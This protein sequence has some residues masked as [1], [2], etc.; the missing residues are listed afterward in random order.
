MRWKQT[1]DYHWR[2][3]CGRYFICRSLCYV[4]SPLG[5]WVFLAWFRCADT[6]TCI[7]EQARDSFDAAV[8][9]CTAHI[10]PQQQLKGK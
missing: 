6:A 9:D 3:E 10:Q 7:S 8:A 2:R 5:A 4:R 1:D